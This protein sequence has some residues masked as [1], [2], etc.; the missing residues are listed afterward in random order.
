VNKDIVEVHA[1]FN[2]NVQGV[3]FRATARAVAKKLAIFGKVRNLNDGRV[4][5]YA[6]A[7][8]PELENFLNQVAIETHGRVDSVE[9]KFSKPSIY[10]KVFEITD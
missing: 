9:K 8:F 1:L 5:I 6:Q 3:G 2:G 10:F 7:T 4:E